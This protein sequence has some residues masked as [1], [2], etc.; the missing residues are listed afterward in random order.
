MYI[1]FGKKNVR[2][3]DFEK[4]TNVAISYEEFHE[5]YPEINCTKIIIDRTDIDFVLEHLKNCSIID[6]Y[7]ILRCRTEMLKPHESIFLMRN[8]NFNLFKKNNFYIQKNS[9]D[10]P[11]F[12]KKIDLNNGVF[13][14]ENVISEFCKSVSKID[15]NTWWLYVEEHQSSGIKFVAGVGN[16]IVFSRIIEQS[17]NLEEVESHI[18]KTLQYI[19]RFGFNDEIKI[20]SA[21]DNF[22]FKNQFVEIIDLKKSFLEKNDKNIEDIEYVLVDFLS[23]NKNVKTAFITENFFRCFLKNH[24]NKIFVFLFLCFFI[25]GFWFLSVQKQIYDLKQFISQNEKTLR[26]TIKDSSKAFE[27]KIDVDNFEYIQ[28]VTK[29]LKE[30]KNPIDIFKKLSVIFK[31]HKIQI[32]T[33]S[34]EKCNDIKLKCKLNKKLSEQLQKLSDDIMEISVAKSENQKTDYEIIDDNEDKNFGAEICI[35]L[36]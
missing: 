24:L 27:A 25:L 32:E 7:K 21:I 10:N 15:E 16:G 35:K 23:K 18:L 14:F 5:N 33:L 1:L 3:F 2:I 12:Y 13:L 30:S 8:D 4:Q 29:F 9:I 22:G 36:K 6:A 31:E 28:Y 17:K 34:M 26:S 19:K 20:I 11:D